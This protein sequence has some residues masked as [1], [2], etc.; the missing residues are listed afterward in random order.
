MTTWRFEQHLPQDHAT[1]FG[2]HERPG[3]AHRL[4]PPFM[5][6]VAAGPTDGIREGSEL[7][8]HIDGVPGPLRE[9]TAVHTRFDPPRLFEDRATGGPLPTWVH[10]HE[11]QEADDGG[12]RL[13]DTVTVDRGPLGLP[14]AS[15]ASR[16]R[17]LFAYRHR[18]LAEELAAAGRY[19]GGGMRVAVSGASGL[20]G[21]ALVPYLQVL[22]FDVVP[23]KRT[24]QSGQGY[25]AWD[26]ASQWVDHEALRTVDA[27]VHLAGEPIG[28]RFTQAHKDEVM[29]SR[30][31]PTRGLAMAAASSERIRTF[32][33]A[34]AIGYYGAHPGTEVDESSPPGEDFLADVCVRW[35]EAA[36]PA[37][38]AGVRTAQIRTGIVLSP[39]GGSLAMQL[40]LFRAGIGGALS[41]GWLSWIALDDLLGVYVHALLDDRAR[42]PVNAVGPNP[43]RGDEFARVL[44]TVL[45]RPSLIPVP[46]F[47]PKLL[48]G[49][50]GAEE[51]ALA[52]QYVTPRE[53]ERLGFTY[54]HT[55][56]R[57]TLAH[58]LNP[59]Y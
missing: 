38:A 44:G 5:G 49:K 37:A 58:I 9:W 46:K 17:R 40:P 54:R 51:L 4:T 33:S 18:Q 35:E 47:G 45:G 7:T 22:G 32:I 12:T 26:P 27:I 24:T 56:L 36:E 16:V 30:F 53:L 11:F 14:P 6:V 25:I 39:R 19:N 52:S 50:Q 29:I 42:G 28:K 2:W 21:R 10:T 59:R 48:L 1:V 8:L 13:L 41:E 3:A 15:V 20:I 31:D 23:M 34:S 57:D 43:V 55:D